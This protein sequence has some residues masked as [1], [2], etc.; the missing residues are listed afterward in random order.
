MTARQASVSII[1]EFQIHWFESD[2]ELLRLE[3]EA[4]ARLADQSLI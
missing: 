1:D 2:P 3:I 4:S